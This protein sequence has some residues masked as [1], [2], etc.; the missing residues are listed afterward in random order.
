MN[1]FFLTKDSNKEKAALCKWSFTSKAKGIVKAATFMV[2]K[3]SR[4]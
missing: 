4:Q 3:K 2:P 1:P